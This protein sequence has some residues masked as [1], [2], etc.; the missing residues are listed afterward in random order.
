MS[1]DE[2]DDHVDHTLAKRYVVAIV[3]VHR[4]IH[5]TIN[6]GDRVADSS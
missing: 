3:V 1:N 4:V 5:G 2:L 6:H